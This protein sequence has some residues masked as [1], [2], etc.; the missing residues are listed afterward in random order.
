MQTIFIKRLIE[1]MEEKDMSQVKL[2]NL[3]GTTNVTISRYISGERKPRIEIVGK[4]AE[5]LG[6]STDYLLGISDTKILP[7]SKK[8]PLYQSIYD[9]L[10]RISNT[11]SKKQFSK[12]QIMII[13]NL[14]DT[15]QDFL[16]KLNT[17]EEN[18]S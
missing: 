7:S 9:K 13:E 16:L 14:L 11:I 1:L 10:D 18:I 5:V 2:A 4:I 6:C 15:N 17:K 12:E 8:N 3:I